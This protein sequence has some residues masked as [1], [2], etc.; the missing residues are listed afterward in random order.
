MKTK[1]NLG[2]LTFIFIIF[3]IIFYGKTGSM[4]IDFSR[5][6]YIP[7]QM[8]NG[9]V[10]IKDIFLIYGFWGY[11]VNSI[12][13]KL[14]TNINLLLIEAHII[15]FLI[16]IMFYLIIKKYL[17]S[18][19]SLIFSILFITMSIFSNSTFS[20]VLP[21]SYS[22]LWGILGIFSTLYALLHKKKKLIFL[23]LSLISVCK[24]ELF[25]PTLI[26]TIFYYNYKKEKLSKESLMLLIFPIITALYFSIKGACINDIKHNLA[27]IK[28]MINTDSINFLYSRMGCFFDLEKFQSR[29]ISTLKFLPFIAISYILFIKKYIY[30]SLAIIFIVLI[31]IST[32]FA[33]NLILLPTTILTIALLIKKETSAKEILLYAFCII[34]CSKAIFSINPLTYSNFGYCLTLAYTYKL[35]AKFLN[36]KWLFSLLLSFLLVANINNFYHYLKN[37][38]EKYST[39]I[40]TLY[41]SKNDKKL[42]EQINIYLKENAKE[43]ETMIVVPEGQIFNLINKKDWNFYNSTF[44]PLDF[45]TF[46]EENIINTLKENKTDYILFY[47]R[48]TIDYGKAT[49]C[50]DYGVDFCTFVM[51]NYTRIAIF[52]EGYKALLFKLNN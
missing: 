48:N 32:N 49:I 37:P 19:L 29:I 6:S 45:E 50:Y 39:N 36:R 11:F 10:L 12:L 24:L 20:F 21:Y 9:N 43:N 46:G 27:L 42:F 47:P 52:E 44:T 40:G 3:S 34:L 2:I 31:F 26:T 33:L 22:T 16:T 41:L 18:K 1:I 4:L 14:A 23:S 7:Y 51:D 25:I 15:A 5:E 8:N 38:K 28:T 30:T 17:D 35:L 13:Y